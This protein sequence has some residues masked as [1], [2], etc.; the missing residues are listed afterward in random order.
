MLGENRKHM[1][2]FSFKRKGNSLQTSAPKCVYPEQKNSA[3]NIP[4]QQ[5]LSTQNKSQSDLGRPLL[6][7]KFVP[8]RPL[9]VYRFVL[10]R[11]ILVPRFHFDA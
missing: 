3:Q 1:V 8:K 7:Y 4:Q 10:G 11:H 2:T 5:N 6:V 9:L